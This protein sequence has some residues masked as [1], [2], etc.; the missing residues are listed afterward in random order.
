MTAAALFT[1]NEAVTSGN[2][3]KIKKYKTQPF[4]ATASLAMT[5]IACTVINLCVNFLYTRGR[6]KVTCRVIRYVY[7]VDVNIII[8]GVTHGFNFIY[9]I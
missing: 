9:N 1:A 5:A 8:A 4:S 7:D 3:R 2:G 6:A